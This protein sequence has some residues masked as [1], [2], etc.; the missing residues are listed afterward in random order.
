[1]A[2]PAIRISQ[3]SREIIDEIAAA[4]GKTTQEIVAEALE[5]YRRDRILDFANEA[6]ARLRQD[7]EAWQAELE[8]RELWDMTLVDIADEPAVAAL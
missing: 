6:Y 8:E 4:S 7:P 1:M 3:A 5:A 2:N